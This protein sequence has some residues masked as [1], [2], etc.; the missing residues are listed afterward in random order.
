MKQ[1]TICLLSQTPDRDLHQIPARMRLAVILSGSK[2]HGNGPHNAA[3]ETIL[4]FLN[5]LDSK[6][7]V[8]HVKYL[9]GGGAFESLEVP[10]IFDI[11]TEAIIRPSLPNSPEPS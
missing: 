2:V 9:M 7:S 11:E 5:Y 4:D 3:S 6:R 8:S 1:I 10:L